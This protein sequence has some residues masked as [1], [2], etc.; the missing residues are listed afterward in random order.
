MEAF[1]DIILLLFICIV[2]EI[3]PV[4]ARAQVLGSECLGPSLSTG[5]FAL[6][7][8]LFRGF[9]LYLATIPGFEPLFAH[10]SMISA[11][12]R[13]LIWD[14]SPYSATHFQSG[15]LL[16]CYFLESVELGSP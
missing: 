5:I 10:Y 15:V 13:P 4:W 3:Q 12:I 11:F 9:S 16:E 1:V 8:P 6:I 14:L 2:A 7:R